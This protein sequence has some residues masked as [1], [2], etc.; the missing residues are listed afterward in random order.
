MHVYIFDQFLKQ[1]KYDKIAAKI[2]TRLTDLG[3]NGK[4]C[5]VGPLKSLRSIV[6]D[7]IKNNPKT[8]VAVG[9]NSTL[10]QIIN[11][12]RDS[13]T[14]VGI[15]PIGPKNSIASYLG[16]KNEDD[17]CNIL[18]ARLIEKI[19]LGVINNQC[20]I[21]N[22][23]IQN[24]QTIIEINGKYTVEPT[25]P[26][27]ITINNLGD[28]NNPRDGL[29]EIEIEVNKKGIL[30]SSTDRSVIQTKRAIINNLAHKNF[31]IDESI[32]V[33]TPAEIGVIKKK[34]NI[35]VGKERAF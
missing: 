10:N 22:A 3:L 12:L 8:I 34:L 35:I 6:V 23:Q 17:A 29:L 4:N 16:I 5:R 11:C 27:A 9:D 31:L 13:E 20:F 30:S 15:I 21:T 26:G 19:D 24:N 1:P 18:A 7:E 33:R 25:G 32:E 28:K 14:T 2:E